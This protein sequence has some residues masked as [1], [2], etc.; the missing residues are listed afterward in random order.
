M[1]ITFFVLGAVLV[2]CVGGTAG[3]AASLPF[4]TTEARY[5]TVTHERLFDAVVEAVQQT[6]VSAQTSG[7]VLEIHYDVDDYVERG[8]VLVRL[9][10]AD[11]RAA[12][13]KAQAQLKEAQ[14][15]YKQADLE[16]KRIKEVFEK[17]LVS[18]SAFDKARAERDAAEA[19]LEA[20]KAAVAQA[21]EQLAYTVVRAPY[22]GIVTE[23]HVE[24][25]ETV[26]PGQSLMTGLSLEKLRVETPVPQRLI[27]RVRELRKA[28]VFPDRPEQ[29]AIPAQRLVFFPYAEAKTNT[30]EVR[31]DLPEGTRGLFPGMFVKV[32]FA[33][34]QKR[35]LVVPGRAV[36]Y[37]SEVTGVYVVEPGGGV[38]LR[39]IRLGRIT[40]DA[41]AEV[42]AG[43]DPGEVVALDPVKAAAYLKER[44]V[45]SL[46]D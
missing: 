18:K 45:E 20:V 12:L 27:N 37:R 13:D 46:H 17:K 8:E 42:L 4:E 23:R 10:D 31:V 32:G 34:G 26:Q 33:V 21:E 43:L 44:D 25:G 36:A 16:Y 38:N 7:R 40:P 35:R 22:S 41:L 1:K 28:R 6:T 24:V 11:Q 30:F 15:R 29:T 5:Q 3:H 19:Q 14:A 2:S 9:R 39:Q